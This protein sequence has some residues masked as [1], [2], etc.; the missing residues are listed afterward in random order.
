VEAANERDVVKKLD[1]IVEEVGKGKDWVGPIVYGKLVIKLLLMGFESR[2]LKILADAK[3][4]FDAHWKKTIVQGLAKRKS[5]R[6]KTEEL[7][8]EMRASGISLDTATYAALIRAHLREGEMQKCISLLEEAHRNRHELEE[9]LYDEL[10]VACVEKGDHDSSYKIAKEMGGT[11][12]GLT[13]IALMV[14][15]RQ[16]LMVEDTQ[17]CADV[18]LRL[19]STRSLT[20][21]DLTFVATRHHNF[22]QLI[23]ALA[24]KDTQQDNLTHNE[25]DELIAQLTQ[26]HEKLIDERSQKHVFSEKSKSKLP[27]EAAEFGPGTVLKG[28]DELQKMRGDRARFTHR[29]NA[30]LAAHPTQTILAQLADLD[31]VTA[32]R[33]HSRVLTCAIIARDKDASIALMRHAAANY[34]SIYTEDLLALLT[35]WWTKDFNQVR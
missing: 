14:F 32:K 3:H 1:A 12:V 27:E 35:R 17:G 24:E 28:F 19:R 4:L 25:R 11:M 10:I 2:A 31:T 30:L 34:G 9:E 5:L 22:A 33:F 20:P 8:R 23:K 7:M 6:A 16:S 18:L 13:P 26:A 15:L 29:Y 21:R